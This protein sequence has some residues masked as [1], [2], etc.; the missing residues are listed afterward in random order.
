ML[1]QHKLQARFR[2]DQR[3]LIAAECA[4]VLARLPL[5]KLRAQQRQRK[6]HAIAADGLRERHD[7][8]RDACALKREEPTGTGSAHLHVIDNHQ[9]VV[10]VAQC[11]HAAQ[12]LIG[13][14]INT[15]VRLRR[16]QNDR[17]RLLHAGVV[18]RDQAFHIRY[19]VELREHIRCRNMRHVVK[20]HACALAGVRIRR[21]R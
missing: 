6:R 15:A 17:R 10:L 21:Q 2:C 14:H 11:A 1:V 12:P 13:Q 8:R 5:V 18:V 3:Q 4:V 16:F 20:R 19:G 9:N 7:V